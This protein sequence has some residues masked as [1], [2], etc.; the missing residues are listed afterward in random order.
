MNAQFNQVNGTYLKA[1]IFSAAEAHFLMAEAAV[2]GWGSNAEVHYLAGIKASFDTWGIG[3]EFGDYADNDG[4]VFDNTLERVMEQKWISG[5]TAPEES[6]FDWRRTGFP[7]LQ[8]GPYAR[9]TVIP[10]RFAYDDSDKFINDV[11]YNAALN[12]L[13]STDHSD[14]V[15]GYGIDS[16]WSKNWLEQGVSN[17]W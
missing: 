10:V 11:N 2:R 16:P 3:H 17:P 6:Y 9:S 1:R 13:Q 14:D 7:D 4:V 8:T 12:S 5:F 15:Q